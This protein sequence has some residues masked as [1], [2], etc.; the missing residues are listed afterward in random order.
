MNSQ[1]HSPKQQ[2]SQRVF[3]AQT[4]LKYLKVKNKTAMVQQ[5]QSY[6]EV[7]D[8]VVGTWEEIKKSEDYAGVAGSLLF[9]K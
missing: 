7:I 6:F 9:Q 5:D 1:L 2:G 4:S 8:S 3:L